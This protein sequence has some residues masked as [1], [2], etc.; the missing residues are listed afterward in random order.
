MFQSF[1]AK[2]PLLAL[3]MVSLAIFL[4]LFLLVVAYVLRRGRALE[5]RGMLP[6]DGEEADR[7]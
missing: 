5:A 6:L 2:S 1:F 3:P 4:S 7:G